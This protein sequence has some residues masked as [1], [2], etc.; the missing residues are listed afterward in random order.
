VPGTI[1]IED[2]R[3]G[4]VRAILERH[5]AFAHASTP[6]EDVYAL[7]VEALLDPA[8]TLY[9][10]RG[11]DG[12]ALGVGAIKELGDGHAEIKSMHIA[13]EARGRGIGRALVAHL[14]G[15]ARERG[16]RQVSLETGSGPAFAPARALYAGA[17]FVPCGAFGDYVPSPNSAYLTLLLDDGD[18]GPASAGPP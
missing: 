12:V 18:G 9:C 4:D 17:G 6:P 2:P 10:Y 5:L 14:L 15:V 7:D 8:V 3:A 11:D 13:A 1:A 16:Y